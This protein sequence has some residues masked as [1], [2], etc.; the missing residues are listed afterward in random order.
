MKNIQIDDD[1]YEFIASQTKQIGESASD[2]LRRL[3]VPSG[4]PVSSGEPL[5]EKT[6]ASAP[7]APM[8][9][10][11]KEAA[12]LEPVAA[13][14]EGIND[15]NAESLSQYKSR[16]EQFLFILAT[17]HNQDPTRF[18]A[19]LDVKGKS[20]I[21]FATSKEALLKAGSSTNPKQIPDS[22]YWVVTN[23]NTGK[24]VAMLKEVGAALGYSAEQVQ[25]LSEQFAPE[26]A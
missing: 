12:A 13:S 10:E 9:E 2:I 8:V 16:V 3:L 19:V 21:Y 26:L 20:R 7:E 24:K 15:I 17:L 14:G 5:P 11:E 1:L 4:A 25:Y 18:S 22:T 23:N 6:S